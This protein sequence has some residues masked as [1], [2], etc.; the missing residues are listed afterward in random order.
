MKGNKQ[1]AYLL[2][3]KDL[4]GMPY[5]WVACGVKQRSATYRFQTG[6][7][8]WSLGTLIAG[9]STHMALRQWGEV[10]VL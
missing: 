6:S 4:H 5:L 1:Q 3:G 8:L 2:Q 9:G 7:S 10:A